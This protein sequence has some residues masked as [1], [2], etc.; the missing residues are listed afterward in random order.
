MYARFSVG[1]NDE[2]GNRLF[3]TDVHTVWSW[4]M[5]I[6]FVSVVI[7]FFISHL[8]RNDHDRR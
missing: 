7:H 2:E 5:A 8:F 4:A 1:T 6:A 3:A